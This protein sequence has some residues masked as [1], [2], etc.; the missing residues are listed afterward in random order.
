MTAAK[1]MNAILSKMPFVKKITSARCCSLQ[2]EKGTESTSADVSLT[3]TSERRG[4]PSS[5]IVSKEESLIE[6]M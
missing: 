1:A 3:I 2:G 6:L 5:R 4:V